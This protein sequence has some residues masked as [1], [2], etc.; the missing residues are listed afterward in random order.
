[1]PHNTDLLSPAERVTLALAQRKAAGDITAG[2]PEHADFARQWA[3]Q[4]P[5]VALPSLLAG[6]PAY[7][8]VKA[9]AQRLGMMQNR[10]PAS[11]E[12]MGAAYRGMWEGLR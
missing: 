2:P 7:S 8:G 5:A 4:N 12:E 6:I 1:M 3:Q 10:S 9:L 11:L